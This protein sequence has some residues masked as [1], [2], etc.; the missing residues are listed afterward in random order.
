MLFIYIT[1]HRAMDANFKGLAGTCKCT[2][3]DKM[4]CHYQQDISL[5]LP[6]VGINY[7][8]SEPMNYTIAVFLLAVFICHLLLQMSQC[9]LYGWS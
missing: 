2:L 7:S 8:I 4:N 1:S 9:G 5:S 3:N 6:M